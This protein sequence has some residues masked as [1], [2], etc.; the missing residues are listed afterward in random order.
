MIKSLKYVIGIF[1]VI[2]L[3]SCTKIPEPG[4]FGMEIV[5]LGN[6]IPSEW[7]DLIAVNSAS[8]SANYVQLWFQDK[9]KNIYFVVYDIKINKFSG[10]YRYLK[11]I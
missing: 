5:K 10:E 4:N 7:G 1:F 11:R 9:D 8:E 6:N 2:L 3:L